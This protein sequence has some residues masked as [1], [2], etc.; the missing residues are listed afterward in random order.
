[1]MS[2]LFKLNFLCIAFSD[3]TVEPGVAV[4]TGASRGIG[5]SIALALGAAGCKVAVNYSAS[6]GAAEEVAQAIINLGGDAIVIK[7]NCGEVSNTTIHTFKQGLKQECS[8]IIHP[9][10]INL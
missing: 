5:R 3:F 6:S 4:V 7:A 8:L 9:V 2:Y 1:V 10:I